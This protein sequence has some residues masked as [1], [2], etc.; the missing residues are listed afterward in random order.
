[1]PIGFFV[2]IGVSVGIIM[3]FSLWLRGVRTR[4]IFKRWARSNNM[5]FVSYRDETGFGSKATFLVVV[6]DREG[7]MHTARV[8]FPSVFVLEKNIRA[9]WID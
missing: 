6:K 5:E 8:A 9:T 7:K 3:F 4:A 1:M 2:F